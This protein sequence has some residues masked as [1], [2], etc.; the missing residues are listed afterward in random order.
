MAPPRAGRKAL[1]IDAGQAELHPRPMPSFADQISR[2]PLPYDAESGEDVLRSL[3]GLAPAV[4]EVVAGA[5]GSSP[6]LRGLALKE[7]HWLTATLSE[8][9]T[10]NI[11]RS[12]LA[13]LKSL[14][15]EADVRVALRRSKRRIALFAALADVAGVWDLTN[16]TAALTDLA[17]CAVETAL[18][19]ALWPLL[20]RGKIPGQTLDDVPDAAGMCVVAMG[21]MG[22]RA[23]NYSSDIDLICLFD[24][25]RFDTADIPEARSAFVKA[26]R[27][28]TALLSEPDADGYVFRTDLRLRPDA[29]VTPVCLSMAAAEAYYESMGRTWERAAHIKAR[30]AAGDIAAGEAYIERLRP[31]IWRK[32]LDFAA[33]QDAF[34]MRKSIHDHKRLHSDALAGRDIKLAPGGIR[35]IEFF[36]QTRQLVAGGRDP[37]LRQPRTIKALQAL[38]RADWIT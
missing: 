21:K 38:T 22:A 16:V 13:G 2:I 30:V 4:R 5:T 36:A 32:H 1:G 11:V 10:D 7:A 25:T 34:D 9:E 19:A 6:Y 8:G 33:I 27:K 24:Q 29:A 12:E 26:T 35:E 28:M 31:F 23:L 15:Q 20:D 37:A 17:D 14:T 3:P 18:R